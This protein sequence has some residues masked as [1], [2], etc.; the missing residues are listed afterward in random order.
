MA[1]LRS[2]IFLSGINNLS[3]KK[4][5]SQGLI[6]LSGLWSLGALQT[7]S[8]VLLQSLIDGH[9]S[10]GWLFMIFLKVPQMLV[11]AICMCS[12]IGSSCRMS[13]Y[14]TGP[15]AVRK[16]QEAVRSSGFRHTMD[17]FFF[18]ADAKWR[19]ECLLSFFYPFAGALTSSVER[20]YQARVR[21][22]ASSF[23]CLP[24]VSLNI[25][26]NFYFNILQRSY[27]L[28]AVTKVTFSPND[29]FFFIFVRPVLIY[30]KM[31]EISV[32][33]IPKIEK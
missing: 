4:I 21:E 31:M 16:E 32:S 30:S 29:P 27:M 13:E 28:P 20:V 18:L 2:Q 15:A 5:S 8:W 6:I 11:A 9:L 22:V 12:Q 3:L 17:F 10:T 7:Y 24:A 19:M 23:P 14:S 26:P 25:F 33:H 1:K